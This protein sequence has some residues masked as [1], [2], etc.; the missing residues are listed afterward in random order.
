M[1][2]AIRH[3]LGLVAGLVVTP[4][5]A[6][7]LMY[8][9]FEL[10]RSTRLAYTSDT[11]ELWRGLVPLLVAALL[12]GLITGTRVSPLASIV[13]GLLFTAVGLVWAIAPRWTIEHLY[14]PLHDRLEQGYSMLGSSGLILVL[15]V[16][17][18]GASLAPSRW[19]GRAAAPAAP[20]FGGAP[21]APSA[22]QP[23]PMSP[24][25]APM[26]PPP[27]QAPAWPQP[28]PQ[29]PAQPDRHDSDDDEPG[30]WT[31]KYGGGHA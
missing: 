2:N 17:L 22:P 20:A 6:G 28:A 25:P 9:T 31:R 3:V 14:R 26:G 30:E 12:L 27:V 19:R 1:P 24:P 11:G 18:L 16:A 8:G 13:P 15:G 29:P 21:P 5:I 7:C 23:A 10:Y 4:L